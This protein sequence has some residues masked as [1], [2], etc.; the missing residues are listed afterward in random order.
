MKLV[1]EE[2]ANEETVKG[3]SEHLVDSH[4]GD[5]C[6]PPV[7]HDSGESANEF[8]E[9]RP[10]AKDGN[11]ATVCEAPKEGNCL[12]EEPEMPEE[13][14]DNAESAANPRKA[15]TQETETACNVTDDTKIL[16]HDYDAAVVSGEEGG[17]VGTSLKGTLS[18]ID[19]IDKTE[20]ECENGECE[21]PQDPH[22]H[23]QSECGENTVQKDEHIYR[24]CES[25]GG[26]C[27]GDHDH[28]GRSDGEL[29]NNCEHK[30]SVTSVQPADTES[31]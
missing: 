20:E 7:E 6:E 2:S 10:N 30:D 21:H 12:N 3:T 24:A 13:N 28:H 22:Q 14:L 31:K 25:G 23:G 15:E 16:G 9:G 27:E 18:S 4:A 29:T 26:N 8:V 19:N 1:E 17:K 5:Q 11:S